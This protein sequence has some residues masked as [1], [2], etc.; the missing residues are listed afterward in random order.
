MICG[1]AGND[2][3]LADIP[4]RILIQSNLGKINFSIFY[5][6]IDCIRNCLRLLMDL[7]HH[8]MF[9]SGLLCCFR[10]PLD[11]LE[12]LLDLFSIQ[13]VKGDLSLFHMSHLLISNIINISCIF[14]DCR[15]I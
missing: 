2:I 8:E 12:F 6:R 4:D 3:D 5:N 10:I 11:R 1:A 15:N 9:K 7:F 13:I 14:Q